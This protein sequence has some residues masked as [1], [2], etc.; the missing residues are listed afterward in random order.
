MF[1]SRSKPDL[2]LDAQASPTTSKF[3]PSSKPTANTMSSFDNILSFQS[4]DQFYEEDNNEKSLNLIKKLLISSNVSLSQ[5]ENESYFELITRTPLKVIKRDSSNAIDAEKIN[6][7]S[8]K[9]F[10]W[11]DESVEGL[12]SQHKLSSI[13]KFIS[14]H[15][16]F[17]NVSEE[18]IKSSLDFIELKKFNPQQTICSAGD[19]PLEFFILHSGTV[20]QEKTIKG[21]QTQLIKG[22][23]AIF[24]ERSL[25]DQQKRKSTYFSMSNSLVWT[26]NIA[27]FHKFLH[28][29]NEEFF[30][31]N[32]AL[33]NSVSLFKNLDSGQKKEI[34]LHLCMQK[35]KNKSTLLN[36][37]NLFNS[38]FLVKKG[39]LT[40]T[41]EKGKVEDRLE[42]GEYYGDWSLSN[43]FLEYGVEVGGG[44]DVLV[45]NNRVLRN[46]LGDNLYTIN[47][48]NQIRLAFGQSNLLSKLKVSVLEEVIA[49]MEINCYEKGQNILNNDGI[50]DTLYVVLEGNIVKIASNR[51]V[52]CADEYSILD[53]WDLI[54]SARKTEK[55]FM[56]NNGILA[57]INKNRLEKIIGMS[58]LELSTQEI[59]SSPNQMV[60]SEKP[61]ENINLNEIYVLKVIGEGQ[62]GIV[63]L[64]KY[65]DSIKA[66]KVCSKSYIISRRFEK[67]MITEKLIQSSLNDFPFLVRLNES[68]KDEDY[69]FLLMDYIEG[70]ELASILYEGMGF[71]SPEVTRFYI[72]QLILTIEYLHKLKILHRDIKL[73]NIL[74]DSEG[75]IK[76]IDFGISKK[77]LDLKTYSIVGTPHYMAPEVILGQGYSYPADFWA[78]GVS[79]YQMLSGNMPFGEDAEDP[80]EV[81]TEIISHKPPNLKEKQNANYHWC[82]DMIEKLLKKDENERLG[83]KNGVNELKS[84]NLLENINW[85]DYLHKNV[86]TFHNKETN[87]FEKLKGLR[88]KKLELFLKQE[89][90]QYVKEV[91]RKSS[92][93]SGWDEMF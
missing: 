66:L 32:L 3:S 57:E 44:T 7:N 80:I 77:M 22:K 49:N 42:I 25:F 85:N 56:K 48:K 83:S 59:P 6:W 62:F 88:G 31:E 9:S 93:M 58:L 41:G 71:F 76:L 60:T 1:K 63:L 69:I 20:L 84:H 10:I 86:N 87:N 30:S 26:L 2:L 11:R 33:V 73:N 36:K 89:F 4:K 29:A 65:R 54:H 43:F 53:E 23:G 18:C 92:K 64:I 35:Y 75:F 12:T 47:W 50:F 55:I 15:Y 37:G 72:I 79:M 91:D 82:C 13:K 74:V 5:V 39:F 68:L 38:F 8:K 81:Y 46:V 14:E 67:Y 21:H 34:C 90:K 27:T 70:E 45:I 28:S 16:L 40:L 51:E 78:I 61:K 52:P 19:Q 24:G 17:W